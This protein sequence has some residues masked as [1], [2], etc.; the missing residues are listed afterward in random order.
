MAEVLKY[1]VD[2]KRLIKL[3][4]P[5][6]TGNLR[7]IITNENPPKHP[8]GRSFFYPAEY[9]GYTLETHY[10]R[11][12]GLAVLKNLCEKVDLEFESIET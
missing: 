1:L 10:D 6:G 9:K 5:W 8:N 11:T 12:R 2:K 4:L 3:P 7:Y